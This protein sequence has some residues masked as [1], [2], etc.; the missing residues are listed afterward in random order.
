[1]IRIFDKPEYMT[2]EEIMEKFYPLRVLIA[3]C[4]V[5]HFCPIGGHV[6]AMETI[7]DDDYAELFDYQIKL[8]DS[9]QYGEV[10]VI[11]TKLP[12]EGES[13]FAEFTEQD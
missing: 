7:P 8:T 11:L 13:I 6:M 9:K 2:V 4:D 5:V 12:L 1:M 10:H 3:N